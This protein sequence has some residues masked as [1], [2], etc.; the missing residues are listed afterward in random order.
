MSARRGTFRLWAVLGCALC[1]CG[2][3][4][5]SREEARSAQSDELLLVALGEARAWQRRADLHLLDGDVTAAAADVQEVLRVRFPAGAPEAEDVR[6]D[7]YARLARLLLSQAGSEPPE[8]AQAT[9][10]RAL[11]QLAEA[12][13]TATRDSFFR[14]HLDAV[15]ADVYEAR[16]R[17]LQD[18]EAQRQARR[19]A[20]EALERSIQI[21]RQVQRALLSLPNAPAAAAASDTTPSRPAAAPAANTPPEP[22]DTTR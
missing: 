2:V 7:A 9:E 14:A 16:A 5:C 22:K 3:A 6:L 4:S 21:D 12:R 1:V 20:L 10:D 19:L 18:P 17:R 11:A 8:A 15:A 13:K